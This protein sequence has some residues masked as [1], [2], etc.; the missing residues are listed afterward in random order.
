MKAQRSIVIGLTLL[1]VGCSSIISSPTPNDD[2]KRSIA[3]VK[4]SM[5]AAYTVTADL[6]QA[7]R[8]SRAS[9]MDVYINLERAQV[10]L[11]AAESN[12]VTN[13]TSA[14]AYIATAL[15]I[16]TDILADLQRVSPTLRLPDGG[17]E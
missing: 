14:T 5:V 3:A 15:Q 9:A 17:A 16:T 11:A 1:L 6:V 10:A 4:I 8:L 13:P 2:A 7:G 12:L